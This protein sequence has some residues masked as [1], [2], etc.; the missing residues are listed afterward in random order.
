LAFSF[1]KLYAAK[2]KLATKPLEQV[3]CC[4]ELTCK[5]VSHKL[6]KDDLLIPGSETSVLKPTATDLLGHF[7]ECKTEII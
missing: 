5:P 3:M 6:F 4:K 1:E 7:R 2:F